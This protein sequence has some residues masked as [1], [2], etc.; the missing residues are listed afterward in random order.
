MLDKLELRKEM[1]STHLIQRLEKPRGFI[2]P[3]SFGGGLRNGGMSA[4]A[5]D[6]LKTIMSF[7]YMGSAEFEWGAVPAAFEF[8]AKQAAENNIRVYSMKVNN[9]YIYCL[10]PIQYFEEVYTRIKQLIEDE[11]K[12]R[13]QEHCGLKDVIYPNA[14]YTSSTVG[15][16]EIDNGFMFFTDFEMYQNVCKLFG[17]KN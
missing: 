9:I 3:F 13:L 8:I 16:I 11:H 15:W 4:K 7:D 10:F 5:M 12:F 14:R 2:N 1:K 6:I 17:I